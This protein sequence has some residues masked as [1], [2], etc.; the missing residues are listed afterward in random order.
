MNKIIHFIDSE[1]DNYKLSM[2][3]QEKARLLTIK[4]LIEAESKQPCEHD[5]VF[6][7]LVGSAHCHKCGQWDEVIENT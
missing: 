4:N 7:G 5:F 2:S 6:V 3:I 1:L